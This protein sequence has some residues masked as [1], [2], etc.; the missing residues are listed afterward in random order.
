MQHRGAPRRSTSTR[1]RRQLR[2]ALRPQ[3]V[4]PGLPAGPPAGR[5]RRA[6]RRGHARRRQRQRASAGTRTSNNFDAVKQLSERAR[7]G[8]GDADGRPEGPRPARHARS[9]VWMGEFGR[10]PK[11]NR[12]QRPRP[13]PQRLVHR[14]GRR[15]HQGRPGRSARPAPTASTVED[16]PVTVPRLPGHRL[17]RRWASTRRSRTMSNVGRP[18]RIVDPAA[19]PIKEVL[20]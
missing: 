14:A 16:R 15:R 2:D 13:L 10:T 18:I 6:V 12:Q 4:R 7:P 8:L 11:I 3:P 17:P 20:A 19:K 5:A 9:I 1:S